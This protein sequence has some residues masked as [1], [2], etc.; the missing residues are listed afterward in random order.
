MEKLKAANKINFNGTNLEWKDSVKYLGVHLASKV[1]MKK[2][3]DEN[4]KK[5]NM[6]NRSCTVYSKNTME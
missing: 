1:L 3:I 2:N 6:L 5:A 4:I